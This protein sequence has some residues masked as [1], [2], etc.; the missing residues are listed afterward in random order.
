MMK[1]KVKTSSKNAFHILQNAKF[2]RRYI[3]E[4][5][6]KRRQQQQQTKQQQ[7]QTKQQQQ[8]NK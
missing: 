1:M 4:H 8:I 5:A 6:K 2:R 3:K 7:Q